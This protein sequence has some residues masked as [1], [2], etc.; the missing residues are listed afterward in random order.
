MDGVLAEENFTATKCHLASVL[1]PAVPIPDTDDELG[2]PPEEES[3][4][5]RVPNHLVLVRTLTYQATHKKPFAPVTFEP[6][7]EHLKAQGCVCSRIA[8]IEKELSGG[9][10]ANV[11]RY[12][13]TN[14]AKP[15]LVASCAGGVV[16]TQEPCV[17]T[18]VELMRK[19]I[20][21]DNKRDAF[22]GDVRLRPGQQHSKVR[23]T[24]RFGFAKLDLYPNA[25]PKFV[26]SIRLVGERAAAEQ[27]LV[28][29]FFAR[30]WIEPR[31]ASEWAFKKEKEK[32]RVVFDYR[33]LNEATLP[34]AHPLPLIENML[35]NESKH[36]I[37]TIV[38]VSKG[39]HQ[40]A[41]HPKFRAKTAMNLA[42]KRY[43]WRVMPM[44]IRNG[45]AIFQ[46]VMDHVLQGLDCA[47]LYVDDILI[48]S[49]GDTEE[50]LLPNHDGDVGAVLD[51]L[52]RDKLVALVSKTDF[53][54]GS[55]QFCGHVLENV[56]GQPAPGKICHLSVG[57]TRIIFVSSGGS[58]G[59]P[60][61][62]PGMSKTTPPYLP[63]SL[64][65]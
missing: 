45:P 14:G 38:D 50:E 65:C 16:T 41:L 31:S 40:I 3:E 25:K 57:Q 32:W 47:D 5:E 63:L 9:G 62:F 28:E 49:S 27:E 35:E 61:F 1:A 18:E 12:R 36:K 8:K 26:K 10:T 2:I 19:L 37:F 13:K 60:T 52:R 43:Q 48:G 23:G 15:L 64:M 29:D 22:S 59:S 44:G 21:A 54:V 11:K 51:R 46:R 4:D 34:D 53:V 58:W 17:S 33:Q 24:E 56:T 6:V 39:F 7:P 42:G 30:G 55:V 20:L